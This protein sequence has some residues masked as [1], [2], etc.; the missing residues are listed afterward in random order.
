MGTT[1]ACGIHILIDRLNN[2][3]NVDIFCI[4]TKAVSTARPT[5]TGHQGLP[6][7]TREKLL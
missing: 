5:H 4:T 6:A 1:T 3:A 2:F 7:K